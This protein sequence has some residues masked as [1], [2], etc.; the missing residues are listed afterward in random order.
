[1]S[2]RWIRFWIIWT[3]CLVPV[4][5]SLWFDN[6]PHSANGKALAKVEKVE[7][8]V[9]VRSEGR[10]IWQKAVVGQELYN[11]D[12]IATENKSRVLVKFYEGRKLQLTPESVVKI[13]L[14]T[15]LSK[16]LEISVLKGRLMVNDSKGENGQGGKDS[17]NSGSQLILKTPEQK[18]QEEEQK[19]QM[20]AKSLGLKEGLGMALAAL[21]KAPTCPPQ[22]PAPEAPKCEAPLDPEASG[23]K[24][25]IPTF[26]AALAPSVKPSSGEFWTVEALER[27]T[28]KPIFLDIDLPKKRPKD[29]WKSIMSISGTEGFMRLDDKKEEDQRILKVTL[30]D[31]L[32]SKVIK[33]LIQPTFALQTGYTLEM[34]EVLSPVEYIAPNTN[35]FRIRSLSAGD[36]VM[37]GF[38]QVEQSLDGRSPWVFVNPKTKPRIQVGVTDKSDRRK[39]FTFVRGNSGNV[40]RSDWIGLPSE[41]AFIVRGEKIVGTIIGKDLSKGEWDRLRKAFAADMI[42]SGSSAAF[43][44]KTT[45]DIDRLQ[46]QTNKVY[47][48]NRGEFVEIE[49]A[50]LKTRPNTMKFVE[51]LSTYMFREPTQILSQAH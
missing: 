9:T 42:Y 38:D 36:G 19:R 13:G 7:G 30:R 41:G 4:V 6:G 48:Y 3:A 21:T 17:P 22:E 20:A 32:R 18:L 45:L 24:P 51:G 44:G 28:E 37:V 50:L 33:N 47:V 25:V 34:D 1:M 49:L 11:N 12:L 31:L 26:D 16:D 43:I 5:W 29:K 8:N 2:N 10:M 15:P 46:A 40:S 39:L 35:V 27:I 14:P 23:E